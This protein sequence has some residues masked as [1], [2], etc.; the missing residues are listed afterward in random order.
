MLEGGGRRGERQGR[1]RRRKRERKKEK[2]IYKEKK[3]SARIEYL[4]RPHSSRA[5]HSKTTR[6]GGKN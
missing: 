3:V 5:I 2:R 1:R 6:A 4:H